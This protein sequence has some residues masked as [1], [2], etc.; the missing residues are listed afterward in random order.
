MPPS[1]M[2]ILIVRA[3]QIRR[4]LQYVTTGNSVVRFAAETAMAYDW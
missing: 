1:Y 2:N 3:K 4:K